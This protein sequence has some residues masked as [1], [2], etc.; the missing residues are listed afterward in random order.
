MFT[1]TVEKESRIKTDSVLIS[2]VDVF[3]YSILIRKVRSPLI[4]GVV[5]WR[6]K[7]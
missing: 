1:I 2:V 6:Y 7:E 4:S 3:N 5:C